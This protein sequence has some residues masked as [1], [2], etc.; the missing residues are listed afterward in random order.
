M[1]CT[2]AVGKGLFFAGW[3]CPCAR[4]STLSHYLGKA[5]SILII[6][7]ARGQTAHREKQIMGKHFFLY[8]YVSI[9]IKH[10]YQSYH[11]DLWGLFLAFMAVFNMGKA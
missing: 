3:S 5:V 7:P 10:N 2:T 4:L 6:Y 11:Q 9:Y 8:F 1:H